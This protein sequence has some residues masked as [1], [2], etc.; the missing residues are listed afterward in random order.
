MNQRD[1]LRAI[2]PTPGQPLPTVYYSSGRGDFVRADITYLRQDF[3]SIERVAKPEKWPELQRFDYVARTRELTV[4]ELAA[5][6]EKR[7]SKPAAT[8]YPQREAVL[9]ALRELTGQDA[10]ENSTDWYDLLNAH[11]ASTEP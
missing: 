4:E 3:S 1:D 5:H 2:V 6:E 11:G 9:F 10:G 7:R 8:S